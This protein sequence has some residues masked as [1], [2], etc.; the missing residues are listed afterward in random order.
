MSLG[1]IVLEKITH[2][3]VYLLK[4]FNF[5]GFIVSIS[6]SKCS[7]YSFLFFFFSHERTKE[8]IVTQ[9]S[10]IVSCDAN[11]LM[12]IFNF[13]LIFVYAQVHVCVNLCMYE[14]FLS[15]RKK[16]VKRDK[17]RPGND[18]KEGYKCFLVLSPL[19]RYGTKKIF[20][21]RR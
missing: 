21:Y 9:L 16:M 4:I 11:A 19:A 7:I 15:R 8:P 13:Q 20:Y 1:T 14:I 2:F 10:R 18:L 3:R 5:V 12:L 6:F 17:C